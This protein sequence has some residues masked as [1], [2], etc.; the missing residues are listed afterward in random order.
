MSFRDDLW[1]MTSHLGN[2]SPGRQTTG[3][4]VEKKTTGRY[5]LVMD[6]KT[7][8]NWSTTIGRTNH[9]AAVEDVR[10]TVSTARISEIK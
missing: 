2:K 4:K 7:G 1:Q 6:D 3:R 5:A 10:N 8:S 9:G